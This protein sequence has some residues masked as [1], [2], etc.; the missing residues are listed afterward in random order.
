MLALP[1][2]VVDTA[3]VHDAAEKMPSASASENSGAAVD[4]TAVRRR[5]TDAIVNTSNVADW[6]LGILGNGL[7]TELGSFVNG[8]ITDQRAD[9]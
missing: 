5:Y 6:E 3:E 8:L 2:P 1:P 9:H 4:R 7:I